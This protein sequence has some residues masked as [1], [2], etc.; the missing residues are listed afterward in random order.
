MPT[1]AQQ[2]RVPSKKF[3]A[4]DKS[5]TN[6]RVI[7][8]PLTRTGTASTKRGQSKDHFNIHHD[9][10]HSSTG[11]GRNDIVVFSHESFEQKSRTDD[12]LRLNQVKSARRKHVQDMQKEKV[13]VIVSKFR[14]QTESGSIRPTPKQPVVPNFAPD[15]VDDLSL[16]AWNHLFRIQ[17]LKRQSIKERR[18]ALR[19]ETRLHT[20]HQSDG[21]FLVTEN[22]IKRMKKG[23]SNGELSERNSRSNSFPSSNNSST[24]RPNF[25]ASKAP[26]NV[27]RDTYWAEW[28]LQATQF[29]NHHSADEAGRQETSQDFEHASLMLRQVY[30]QTAACTVRQRLQELSEMASVTTFSKN[31]RICFCEFHPNSTTDCQA[32]M[33]NCPHTTMCQSCALEYVRIRIRDAEVMPWIPC[34]D[35]KCKVPIHAKD[36]CS[37]PGMTAYELYK[38]SAT[39]LTKY[40]ARSDNWAPCAN[41]KCSFGFVCAESGMQKCRA[42][43][44]QQMVTRKPR[45]VSGSASSSSAARG[46][47]SSQNL[48]PVFQ[49]MIQQGTMRPCP[50]CGELTIKEYGICNV[51][52]C[53]RCGIWWNWRTRETGQSSTD[54]KNKARTA[55]TL[56]EGGE[57]AYQLELERNNPEEFKRF[58]S[59]NGI[60]YNPNYVRGAG[61][62]QRTYTYT[63]KQKYTHDWIYWWNSFSNNENKR[64]INEWMNEFMWLNKTQ[65]Q[66]SGCLNVE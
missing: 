26:K 25:S 6:A 1:F 34:A 16:E 60:V 3:G 32:P 36:I 14:K 24:F 18:T 57:L 58:L 8:R 53:A 54:L 17:A 11:N 35:E 50:K 23:A 44:R 41:E 66:T 48:D 42:C 40:L 29:L 7:S 65:R 27:Q 45:A 51:I 4:Q 2:Q 38:L 9:H 62:M 12:K 39:L 49:Q 33:T 46:N 19:R 13:K 28:L 52:E 22:S 10:D 55:G 5:V 37:Y 64:V 61:W 20:S 63:Y 43:G 21:D 56:W 31:C 30:G 15:D 59:R 47:S